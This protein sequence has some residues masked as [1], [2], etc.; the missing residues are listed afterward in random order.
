MRKQF[1]GR[2]RAGWMLPVFII[3]VAFWSGCA[4][5]RPAV[6]PPLP[7]PEA[8][9][10][11]EE[12][13]PDADNGEVTE[14]PLEETLDLES[15]DETPA[16]VDELELPDA[17]MPAPAVNFIPNDGPAEAGMEPVLPVSG[18]RVQVA[19][20]TDEATARSMKDELKGAGHEKIHVRY[21]N[22]RYS[23]LVG[24]F[25]TEADG[26]PLR[27]QLR[28]EGYG[29]AFLVFQDTGRSA[30]KEPSQEKNVETKREE[31]VPEPKTK[32]AQGWR[33]QVMSL[34]DH[35]SAMQHARQMRTKTGYFGYVAEV[36]GAYKVRVGDFLTRQ[37]AEKARDRLVNTFGY[38][39]SYLVESTVLVR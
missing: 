35:S 9:P 8:V 10:V 6:A 36:S 30:V 28:G 14:S 24:T 21:E 31:V 37:E 7:E 34:S 29:A 38:E 18:W 3:T 13:A 32:L 1:S 27:D 16:P 5:I 12:P 15:A 2:A 26:V 17:A 11:Q 39:G 4:G 23:V 19:A 25:P 22:E 20:T 33:V